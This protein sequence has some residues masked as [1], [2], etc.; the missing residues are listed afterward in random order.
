MVYNKNI[1]SIKNWKMAASRR[2]IRLERK[3]LN[4]GNNCN[5]SSW[6]WGPTIESELIVKNLE[7]LLSCATSSSKIYYM[8]I[9]IYTLAIVQWN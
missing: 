3:A 8:Y 7:S 4:N 5:R 9:S 1:E 2:K 6:E